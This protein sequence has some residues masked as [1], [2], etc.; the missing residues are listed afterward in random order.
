MKKYNITDY[1]YKMA[2]K[3]GVDIKPSDKKNKKIDVYKNNIKIASIGDINYKDYP[4]YL[5]E[6]KKLANERRALYRKRHSK[7]LK[8]VGSPGYY[9][10][11]ILW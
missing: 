1:S 4:T 10:S 7:D 9:A 11:K 5:K 3:L 6:D 2:D 8:V